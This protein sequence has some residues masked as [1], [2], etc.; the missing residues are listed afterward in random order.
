MKRGAEK[1]Q[2]KSHPLGKMELEKTGFVFIEH[3]LYVGDGAKY[4]GQ[5]GE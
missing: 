3:L 2:V 4:Q 5:N 1:L